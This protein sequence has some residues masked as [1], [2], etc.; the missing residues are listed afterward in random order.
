MEPEV[1]AIMNQREGSFW[2]HIGMQRTIASQLK[3]YASRAEGNIILDAGCGTGGMF[4]LLSAYGSVYGIDQSSLAVQYAKAKNIAV[5]IKEASITNIPFS[6]NTFDIVICLDVLY[7]TLAG[8]DRRAMQEFERV[9]KP[10]GIII[11]REPAY[12][13]LRGHHDRLVWTKNRYNK[14]DLVSKLEQAGFAVNKATYLVFFLFPLALIGRLAESLYQPKN[15][16]NKTFRSNPLINSLLKQFL[17]LEAKLL[18]WFN[19]PFGLSV[20]CIAR[21]K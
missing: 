13:W 2:W 15:I 12:N 18:A 3:K 5:A 10:G 6:N 8:N 9:L 7:H 20:M 17:F 19:F 11:V 4:N 21:K 1:Y 16:A 14:K